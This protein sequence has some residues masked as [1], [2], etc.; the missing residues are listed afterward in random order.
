M[1]MTAA[2]IERRVSFLGYIRVLVCNWFTNL[3]GNLLVVG[4][5]AGS[6]IIEGGAR[7]KFVGLAKLKTQ[8]RTFAETTCAAILAN[9][10]VCMAVS[11]AQ[12]TSS[13]T[14]KVLG[15]LL[16]GSAFVALEFEHAVANMTFIPLGMLFTKDVT[17]FDFLFGNLWLVSAIVI[18]LVL[19]SDAK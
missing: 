14:G 10:L 12:A 17:V 4:L 7:D 3:I 11:K 8:E 9:M 19:H 13:F 16:P 5:A 18:L 6:S 15:T 2:L 1:T